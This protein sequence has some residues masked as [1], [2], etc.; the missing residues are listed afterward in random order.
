[1]EHLTALALAVAL[2]AAVPTQQISAVDQARGAWDALKAGRPDQAAAAFDRALRVAPQEP[3]LLLGAGIA[4]HLQGQSEPARRLLFDALKY[5]PTL[6]DASLVLGDVLYRSNDINGAIAVYEQALVHAP[7]HKQVASRLEAWRK[8]AALHDRFGQKLGDHFTVLF[9]GPAE[10]ELAQ[11]AVAILEAAYWRIGGALYTYP[12][13]VI[14]V[15]LYTREQFRDVT[16]S[17][18][19]AGGLYDGRIR[20]PV[21]GAME[22][23]REFERVLAHEFTHALI[24]DLATRG[25]PVWLSE[26]LAVNFEGSD[27]DAQVARLKRVEA[28]PALAALE[29]SFA[30]LDVN[31]AKYA[32][33]QSAVAVRLLLEEAGASAVVGILTDLGR[34]TAFAEAFQRNVNMS[35]QE[36]Q[37]R[38]AGR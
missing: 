10:A 5:D 21:R 34:G 25:V 2:G 20:M 19:W 37:S 29:G 6:T 7:D 3:T 33:A 38:L 12:S 15:V 18:E 13:S 35:Y 1:M 14:T 30:R 36:F 24:H 31:A 4:A 26:G 11:R 8:E 17:P 23:A 32:Y 22:T 28:R 9:E 16:Q 27:L